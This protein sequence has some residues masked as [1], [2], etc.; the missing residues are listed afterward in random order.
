MPLC[1]LSIL[2]PTCIQHI[3]PSG[4]IDRGGVNPFAT[5]T[6]RRSPAAKGVAAAGRRR[7]RAIGCAV[8][9]NLRHRAHGSAVRVQRYRIRFAGNLLEGIIHT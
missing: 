2:R 9:Y 5:G 3:V 4:I 6:L 7:Q 8:N 1:C